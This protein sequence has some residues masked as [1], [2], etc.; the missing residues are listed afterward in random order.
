M[1]NPNIS[2]I[3]KEI[4]IYRTNRTHSFVL[5]ELETCLCIYLF[6]FYYLILV[7][8][9]FIIVHVVHFFFIYMY[10]NWGRCLSFSLVNKLCI[11]SII[12]NATTKLHM[13]V[14]PLRRP[15]SDYCSSTL[16]LVRVLKLKIKKMS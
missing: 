6:F 4:E 8:F 2:E 3:E 16:L 11:V 12:R 14:L 13:E 10:Q 5:L 15:H 9:L 7:I 1:K